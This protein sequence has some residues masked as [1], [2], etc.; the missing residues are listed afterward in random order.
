MVVV[1]HMAGY[2]RG[3]KSINILCFADDA[4]LIANSEDN[5]QWLL[6]TRSLEEH[7][8][9]IIWSNDHIILMAIQEPDLSQRNI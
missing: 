6:Y 1:A 4:V 8:E 5:L 2:R 9:N 7:L 3:N